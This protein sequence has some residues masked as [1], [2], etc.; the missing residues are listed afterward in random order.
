MFGPALDQSSENSL[1][2]RSSLLIRITDNL[3]LVWQMPFAPASVSAGPFPLLNLRSTDAKGQVGSTCLHALLCAVVVFAVTH[4]GKKPPG[5]IPETKSAESLR[6]AVPNWLKSEEAPSLGSRGSGGDRDSLPPTAG[7]LAP[8]ARFEFA[9]PRLPDNKMHSL[10]VPVTIFDP[11]AP[12]VVPQPKDLGLPWLKTITNSAGPGTSGIGNR[13][14]HGMGDLDGDGAGQGDDGLPFAPAASP[15]ICKY[16]P[17]PVYT[18]EARQAKL[19]GSVTLRVLV[20]PDGRAHS[21]RITKGLGLGLDER[22]EEA[23]KSWQFIPAKDAAHRA[24]ASWVV[25][26]TTYHLF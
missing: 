22:A 11:A 7:E 19:Q 14:G 24:T 4:P 25:I 17:D 26:E 10:P 18:D 9:P 8:H 21:I 3:K 5:I 20:G 2:G 13:N 12:D 15:V 23:V 16:C 1:L 6:F